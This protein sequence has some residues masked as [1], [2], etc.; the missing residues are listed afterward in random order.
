MYSRCAEMEDGM[1]IEKMQFEYTS[2]VTAVNQKQYE[3]HV[4]LYEGYVKKI[5]EVDEELANNSG[6]EQANAVYSLYRGLK[7]GETFALDGVIL[8][9]LYFENMKATMQPADRV[10]LQ[11]IEDSFSSYDRWKEDFIATG[12]A[13]RGW[14]MLVYDQRS[15][16]F[17][18]I[19]LD[20]HDV[21]YVALSFPILVM[22]VYE[23]AYFAQYGTDKAAY[24]E[25]FMDN[26]DWSVINRRMAR[27]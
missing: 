14:A 1:K 4:K 24:I 25:K 3:E 2:G 12:K 19:S 11:H 18:N 9:E 17:R 21:G 6:T 22:D 7:R 16:R 27:V 5:N 10:T 15:R 20:A 13:S 23:H 8:H 26:I